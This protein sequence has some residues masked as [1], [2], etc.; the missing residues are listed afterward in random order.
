MTRRPTNTNNLTLPE[1]RHNVR[2]SRA[3]TRDG[4]ALHIV[5]SRS[6]GG[7]QYED[8]LHIDRHTGERRQGSSFVSQRGHTRQ[9]IARPPRR[10]EERMLGM[11]FGTIR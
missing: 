2:V 7:R 6:P 4:N 9:R 3:R 5:R 8:H 11:R 10:S 1:D